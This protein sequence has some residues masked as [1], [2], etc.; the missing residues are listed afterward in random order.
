MT[1]SLVLE[2]TACFAFNKPMLMFGALVLLAR[3][4][5]CC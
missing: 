5:Y 1:Q 2:G 3:S 4:V